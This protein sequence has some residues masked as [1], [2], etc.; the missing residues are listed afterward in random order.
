MKSQPVTVTANDA[1]ACLEQAALRYQ[2]PENLLWGIVS[3]EGGR[4]GTRSPN[5]NGTFDLGPA[6]VNTAWLPELKNFG[7]TAEHLTWNY[8]ANV[9]VAAW[10]LAKQAI[11]K[12]DWFK[13]TMA[14]HLGPNNWTPERVARGHRY[15]KDVWGRWAYYEKARQHTSGGQQKVTAVARN[16][17]G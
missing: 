10:I 5:S 1:V 9:G 15:A 8:C 12:G 17:P 3:K 16:M 7:I 4:V 14:Y 6:Q 2:I 11:A 13:A